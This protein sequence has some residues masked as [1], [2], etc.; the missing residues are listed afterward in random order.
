[1][2]GFA[3]INDTA[4][5]SASAI[6]TQPTKPEFERCYLFTDFQGIPV[7]QTGVDKSLQPRELGDQ[8]L[9]TLADA[10]ARFGMDAHE[11]I[12]LWWATWHEVF[13]PR[14]EGEGKQ[15]AA[16]VLKWSELAGVDESA[17]PERPPS[18]MQRALAVLCLFVLA[19]LRLPER[20]A[21]LKQLAAH[22]E[23]LS[24]AF[25]AENKLGIARHT[26]AISELMRTARSSTKQEKKKKGRK[27][28]KF[29]AA[30]TRT[31]TRRKLLTT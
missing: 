12:G 11:L 24:R 20:A 31:W 26:S 1:M 4:S 6:V 5:S 22:L 21:F 16:R 15:E 27:H 28:R 8:S 14:G 3:M 9:M 10:V 18:P 25:A 23:K 29:S 17:T 19:P 2:R 13:G 30:T 7:A